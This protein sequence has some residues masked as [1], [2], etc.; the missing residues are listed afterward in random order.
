M[1]NPILLSREEIFR[2]V[3]AEL[4]FPFTSVDLF[5]LYNA[6]KNKQNISSKLSVK[7]SAEKERVDGVRGAFRG[8]FR[9]IEPPKSIFGLLLQSKLLNEVIGP[10]TQLI[11]QIESPNNTFFLYE[12]GDNLIWEEESY[13]PLGY[14]SIIHQLL[15][16]T[17]IYELIAKEEIKRM[18]DSLDEKKLEAN[19][20]FLTDR[21]RH[22][23]TEIQYAFASLG[24]WLGGS[25]NMQYFIHYA[26]KPQISTPDKN[27]EY[28]NIMSYSEE[29]YK[30]LTESGIICVPA[31]LA[32]PLVEAQG[33]KLFFGGIPIN[34]FNAANWPENPITCKAIDYHHPGFLVD[35]YYRATFTG[36]DIHTAEALYGA[37]NILRDHYED[38]YKSI[39]YNELLRCKH[40]CAPIIDV[41]SK[42]EIEE[43]ISRIPLRGSE[44]IV[45]RGQTKMRYIPR[46]DNI[47]RLLFGNSCSL[48]PSLIT[49]S[50][51]GSYNYDNLHFLLRYYFSQEF[52]FNK[53]KNKADYSAYKKIWNE[54]SLDPMCKFDYAIIALAQHYGLP[55]NGLDVTTDIDVATWFAT[56]KY[57]IDDTGLSSYTALK[58]DTWGK[59]SEDFPVIY[60]CQPVSNTTSLSLHSCEILDKL[61]LNALRPER[62]SAKFFLGAHTEHQNRLAEAIV[63]AFRLLP[64]TYATKV[65]FDYLFPSPEEDIAYR[66]M[67][68]LNNSKLSNFANNTKV[69]AYH[70]VL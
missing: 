70:R 51:R 14:K 24:S 12:D 39:D 3:F 55:T 44:Q 2:R 42:G 34:E 23:P 22:M 31:T 4:P 25:A 47:K 27:N 48:E 36:R 7:L 38:F 35:K 29:D 37:K 63:C 65:N 57:T 30:T 10:D 9:S 61:G 33:N 17:G 66:E 6:I 41:S 46:S 58:A 20:S 18:E 28:A 50:E 67:L 16:I 11:N 26:C 43:I 8:V 32:V 1:T 40:Y 54:L 60:V 13:W 56:N 21:P 19:T 5:E 62:Q 59:N 52:I 64:S 69:A 53:A 68:K 15:F 49:S 45:F